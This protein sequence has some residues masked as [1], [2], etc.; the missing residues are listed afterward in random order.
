M[1]KMTKIWGAL[2]AVVLFG[3]S[4]SVFAGP[5]TISH[6]GT[7]STYYTSTQHAELRG[8]TGFNWLARM[9]WQTSSERSSFRA[10]NMTT[11]TEFILS[12]QS[13]PINGTCPSNRDGLSFSNMPSGLLKVKMRVYA[14]GA[15]VTVSGE[16]VAF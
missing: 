4:S 13:P 5:R 7:C 14:N 3:V 12:L 6:Y 15:K 8:N 9:M 2:G 1:K 10:I 16:W 11:G